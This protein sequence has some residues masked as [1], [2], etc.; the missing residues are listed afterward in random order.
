MEM[1]K[2]AKVKISYYSMNIRGKTIYVAPELVK[3]GNSIEFPVKGFLHKT[4][5][6][7]LIL[8]PSGYY[9]TYLI[10]MMGK[11]YKIGA[12]Y[13]SDRVVVRNVRGYLFVSAE[14]GEELPLYI[15]EE[16]REEKEYR[17]IFI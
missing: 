5:C 11:S 2:S 14:K 4:P 7:R 3:D 17:Y 13:D 9:W 16:G 12:W 6:G 10:D 8:E 15:K 1:V